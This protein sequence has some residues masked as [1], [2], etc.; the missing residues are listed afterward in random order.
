ME[1]EE[2]LRSPVEPPIPAL[3]RTPQRAT[4]QLYQGGAAGQSHPR[5]VLRRLMT[6]GNA[7]SEL[8]ITSSLALFGSFLSR[9]CLL[10]H[11]TS[12]HLLV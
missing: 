6:D 3:V 8:A 10:L 1:P 12:K 5:I 11:S 4:S 2:R 7:S 9:G